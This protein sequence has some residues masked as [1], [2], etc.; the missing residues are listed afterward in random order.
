MASVQSTSAVY[1]F[2]TRCPIRTCGNLKYRSRAV[3]HTEYVTVILSFYHEV[4]IYIIRIY[5]LIPAGFPFVN[6]TMTMCITYEWST[7]TKV[8]NKT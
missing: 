1:Y 4:S 2:L 8:L 7:V 3:N 6:V 5:I